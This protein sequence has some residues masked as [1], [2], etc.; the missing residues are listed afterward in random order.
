MKQSNPKTRQF[1]IVCYCQPQRVAELFSTIRHYA[2]IK[3]DKDRYES[4]ENIGEL[5]QEHYHLLVVLENPRY[6]LAVRKMLAEASKQFSLGTILV[7]AV[8]ELHSMY[9]YI[10]HLDPLSANNEYKA[11]YDVKDVMCDDAVFWDTV[12]NGKKAES[13]NKQF[14]IDLLTMPTFALAVKYGRDFIRNFSKYNDFI[15]QLKADFG[16]DVDAVLDNIQVVEAINEAN[17]CVLDGLGG[18]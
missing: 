16:G 6:Y 12:L 7:E 4:G 9:E 11:T 13:N 18:I 8:I 5:K 2:C 14:L 3:H 15:R 1:S 10:L 17:S